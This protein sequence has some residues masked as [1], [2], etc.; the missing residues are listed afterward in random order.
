MPADVIDYQI[1]GDDMQ[2]VIITLDPDEAVVAEAGAMM[3]LEP[4][5]EMATQMSMA[6]GKGLLGKLFEAG[7]RAVTGES[8]FTTFFHNHGGQ[9]RDCAFAAPYPGHVVPIELGDHGGTIICQKDAF[10][11]QPAVSRCRSRFSASWASGCSAARALSCR[12]SRAR[13]GK[14]R[15]LCTR[16]ARP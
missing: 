4:D 14:A 12:S 9:R 7:K 8:F 1:V 13:T 16:A 6:E 3:Y 5:I 2:A 10:L 11:A 15:R